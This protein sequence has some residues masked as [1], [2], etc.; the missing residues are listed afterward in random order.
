VLDALP[1][2]VLTEVARHQATLA[3]LGC[4]TLGDVRLLPRGGSSR[5]FGKALIG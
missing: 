1:L 5:R 4:R 3:R 2:H